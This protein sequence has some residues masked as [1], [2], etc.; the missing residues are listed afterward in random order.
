MTTMSDRLLKG[1]RTFKEALHDELA[2]YQNQIAGKDA[3]IRDL[4]SKLFE[5]RSPAADVSDETV[6]EGQQ[7]EDEKEED[8]SGALTKAVEK[9]EP[10]HASVSDVKEAAQGDEKVD[11]DFRKPETDKDTNGDHDPDDQKNQDDQDDE[12]E[13]DDDESDDDDETDDEAALR[14]VSPKRRKKDKGTKSRYPPRLKKTADGKPY[15]LGAR[16]HFLFDVKT[17]EKNVLTV[18]KLVTRWCEGEQNFQIQCPL[19]DHYSN[20]SEFGPSNLIKHIT[21]NHGLK[22]K[23]KPRKSRKSCKSRKS[24]K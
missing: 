14:P 12:E 17:D 24:R 4:R 1:F 18:D 11:D 21:G 22:L 9:G 10:S 23:T 3:E 15:I 2:D 5:H 8:D 7:S 20:A 19:C 13:E 6:N 16:Q